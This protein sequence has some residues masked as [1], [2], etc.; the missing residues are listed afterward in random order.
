MNVKTLLSD[1]INSSCIML[2]L[3]FYSVNLS[4]S[5][6]RPS[7]ILIVSDNQSA[8]LLNTY[9]NNEI[10]TPNIDQLARQGIKFN[11]AFAVNGVCSPTR[12]TLFTGLMPSQTGVHVALP[13]DIAVPDWSAIE[14]F[15][16]LPQTFAQAGYNTGLVGK[17]HL[18]IAQKPQ[19]GFQYWVTFP[20]G[21]TTTFY[22]QMVIDNGREYP[23]AEHLTDY[24]TKKALEF[25]AQQTQEQPFF[26]YLA[27]NGPYMLPPTVNMEPKNRHA[28]HYTENTPS[29][30]QE[31]IHRYLKNWAR[32][33]RGPSDLMVREGTTAWSAI[34][35]LNNRTAMINTAS[36]TTMVDD[37]VGA[38]MKALADMGLDENTL[39]IY[40]SDQGAS[41]GQ[42]GLWGNTS[43]SFP[44]TAYN[45]N[46]QIPLIMHHRGRIPAGMESDRYINQYDLFP[47]LLQYAGLG[48]LEIADTPG[49]SFAPMMQGKPLDDWE[50]TAFFEFVTV[51][52]IRTP[53]WKYMK[54]FDREWPDTLFDMVNDPGEMN[55]LINNPAYT[56]IIE[57]LDNQ[58]TR[59]FDQYNEPRFD[60][61]KG[62]TG[63]GILLDKY[64]GRND[65][66]RDRFPNWEEPFIEKANRVFSDTKH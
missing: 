40:T 5:T 37:G 21:H 23:V 66:F 32:G 36:E 64:Y 1:L 18:G 39:V 11:N 16:S 58:L 4:A 62:G 61:W 38:I 46:M 49:K 50:D 8:S 57:N 17:Y 56:G 27:Y 22:D 63:K 45:S 59:F 13:S 44:F 6:S 20:S 24:W 12:A 3:C 42:H 35:A 33:I 9:G 54:R 43:W 29:M 34:E 60:L 31:K 25:L 51:R 55:N 19:L 48:D 53:E 52:V 14:E 2:I 26:L 10:R 65:I 28:A 47:T 30:P 41:Y 15:R 7:I